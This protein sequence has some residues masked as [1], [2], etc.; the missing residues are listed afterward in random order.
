MID[1]ALSFLRDELS[2]YL[3]GLYQLPDKA[4]L[5]PLP[6]QNGV[7]TAE[8]VVSI[9]LVNIEP[10]KTIR[11]LSADRVQHDEYQQLNPALKLNLRVLFATNFTDYTESLKFLAATLAFFQGRSV[12]TPQNSPRLKQLERLV[13]ELE[14]TTY[15][16]WSFLASMLGTKHTPSAIYKVRMVTIQDDN[17]LARTPVVQAVGTSVSR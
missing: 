5:A 7:P 14:T 17:V 12:F 9:T 4:V 2:S 1:L 10:E 15:Q 11:N 3:N 8:N 16:D 6:P 13:L